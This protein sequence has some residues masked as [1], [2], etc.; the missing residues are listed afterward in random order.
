MNLLI[1]KTVF[2]GFVTACRFADEPTNL[3]PSF[4][5]ATT[6]GVVLPPSAFGTSVGSLL[7]LQP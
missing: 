4:V 7:P 1:E 2:N 6:E 5:K 3:S